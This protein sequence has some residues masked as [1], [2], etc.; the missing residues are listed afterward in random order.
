MHILAL[1]QLLTLLTLANGAPVIAKALIGARCSWPIDGGLRFIDGRPLLGGSKTIRGILLAVL[2]TA[3]GAPVVGLDPGTG[4]LVGAAAMVGD[5][6]SSFAKRRMNLPPS[7]RAIGLDQVPESLLP[8]LACRGA[9]SLTAMDIAAAV[10]IFF[11]GE[12]V[13]SRL[14]YKLHVRDRPY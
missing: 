2:A 5:L 1:S 14:L 11:I 3:A 10:L 6:A 4:A 12:I 7:S 13:L 9:L 8:A